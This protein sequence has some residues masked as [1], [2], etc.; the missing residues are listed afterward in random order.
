MGTQRLC[1]RGEGLRD[2]GTLLTGELDCSAKFDELADTDPSAE[3]CKTGPHRSTS[4]ASAQ[5]HRPQLLECPPI[6]SI[7]GCVQRRLQTGTAGQ[8]HVDEIEVCGQGGHNIGAA[9]TGL[10]RQP[11]VGHHVAERPGNRDEQRSGRPA[12]PES[13]SSAQDPDSDH[14]AHADEWGDDLA[15]RVSERVLLDDCQVAEALLAETTGNRVEHW[16]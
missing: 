12:G 13:C 7:G 4:R 3:F 6:T 15:R 9:P 11:A 8:E 2:A 16:R 14:D 10:T 1:P 5:Q